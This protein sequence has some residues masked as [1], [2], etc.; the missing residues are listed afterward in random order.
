MKKI[1]LAIFAT[2]LIPLSAAHANTSEGFRAI[3]SAQPAPT[4]LNSSERQAFTA[5]YQA[6]KAQKW[7][8]AEKLIDKAPQGPMAAMARAEYYLAPNSPK[9]DAERLQALLQSAP[10]LPQAE[11]LAAMAKKRGAD[12]LPDRPGI[13]RFSWLGGAPKRDLPANA[14]SDSL[15]SEL[16]VFIK[17]DDPA[18]AERILESKANDLTTDALTEL[19]YRVA[20]SYYIENDDQSAKRLAGVARAA[21]GEWATQASWAY[22]LASWRL[23]DYAA[24]FEAFDSVARLASNDDL[25]AAGLFWSARAAMAAKQPQQVQPRMQYA[26]KLPETFYGLL[27]SE[28]LGMEPIARKAAKI[29]KLDWNALKDQQ[30]ALLAVALTEVGQTKLA[31][32]ALR[33]QAKI[34]DARQHA[35]LA[36]LAG[37][38]NLAS[39]QYWMGHYGPSRDQSNAMARY[40][41]PNWEPTGGWR[42][43]PSLVYAHAL[44]ESTFRTDVVSPA[45]ARGLMQVR[46]GTAQDIARARGNSFVASELDRPSVNLEYGQSYLEKLRDMPSTGGLLPKV[47]A[48]YNAG[49]TPL[50]RWNME[51]RDNGDPL[52]FVESIPYWETRGYVAIILRNYWIYEMRENKASGSLKGLAQYLWP[53]FPD[54]NGNV[55]A[56]RMTGGSIASR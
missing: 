39:T 13:R 23:K 19:R 27:A 44:Q 38:L 50:A 29:S 5:I 55:L 52:L 1:R 25:K 7:D 49:P 15:R 32:E 4:V 14:A 41:M 30:N 28:S 6:I 35:N 54:G 48:A 9:V 20:W 53:N 42:V 10:Y 34:G 18:S 31:D 2:T 56:R 45:G 33:H 16:Q 47:I 22:G 17:N 36:Q 12:A 40:P 21:G 8:E 11:Q 24:A 43:T 26:A 46:L 3:V 37:S 51:I